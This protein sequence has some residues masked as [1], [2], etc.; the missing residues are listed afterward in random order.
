MTAAALL[1]YAAAVGM[2][3]PLMLRGPRWAH[4]SPGPAL[5]VWLG[6]SLSFIAAVILAAAQAVPPDG[7][8][9]TGLIGLLDACGLALGT[10]VDAPGAREAALV[11]AGWTP[12]VA[13]A[14]W[15]GFW[16]G[17]ALLRGRRWRRRHAAAVDLVG[18]YAPRHQAVVL[19]HDAPAAYCLPGR[20]PRIVITQG[21]LDTLSPL[22]L[23]A[24]L[25]HERAH[26]TG[27]HHLVLAA[28]EAFGRAFP[29]LPLARQSHTEVAL[30]LEML[31]D[32]RAVRSHGGDAVAVALCE[33]AAGSAPKAAFAA[34]GSGALVR[35]RRVLTPAPAHPLVLRSTILLVAGLTP[36]IPFLVA[37]SA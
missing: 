35:I 34:G 4:R 31:A 17:R 22:Q 29:G 28:V 5:A 21:T 11:V 24:V 12:P 18:R 23:A 33:V 14:L 37:C 30:L 27:R 19:Q 3:G 7:R 16:Y 9:H 2:A 10:P 15:V 32:D 20:D 26:I 25:A 36:A 1:T 8:V 6:L 13:V